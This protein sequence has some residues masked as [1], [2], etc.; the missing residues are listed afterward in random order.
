MVDM[1]TYTTSENSN[2]IKKFMFFC[3][4]LNVPNLSV[5]A[6]VVKRSDNG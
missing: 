2:L 4:T 1:P 6:S 3:N 5:N